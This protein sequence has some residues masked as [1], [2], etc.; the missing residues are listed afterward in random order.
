LIG[1]EYPLTQAADAHVDLM[2][3]RTIG[4]LVLDPSQ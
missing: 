4:K 2:S 3:R 1:G